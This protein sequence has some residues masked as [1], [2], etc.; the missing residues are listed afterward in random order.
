MPFLIKHCIIT[1]LINEAFKPTPNE[2]AN[3]QAI[4]DL[5]A[6]SPTA[7]VVNHKG[8]MIDR[9]GLEQAQQVLELA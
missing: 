5:F 3:A 9:T 8:A 2:C 4:V 1:L 6:G 7:A